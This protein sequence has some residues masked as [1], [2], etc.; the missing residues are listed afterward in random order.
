MFNH[1][2]YK[3]EDLAAYKDLAE[4]GIMLAHPVTIGDKT[5]RPDINLPYHSSIK[6]FH[7][8]KD[9]SAKAHDIASKLD[10]SPPNPKN[11]N[12]TPDTFKDRLGND[13]HVLKLRGSSPDKMKEHNS[14][15]SHM[16][17]PAKHDF[18]AHV[19]VDKD[20]WHKIKNSGAK[21]AHEAGLK[22]GPAQLYQGHKILH[23]YKKSENSMLKHFDNK[24][25]NP[26][27]AKEAIYTNSK[28]KKSHGKALLLKDEDFSRYIQD[29]PGLEE[30]IADH[31]LNRLEHH[32]GQDPDMIYHGWVGGVKHAYKMKR[33]NKDLKELKEK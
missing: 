20:T 1:S 2:L 6:V 27:V 12:I 14:K 19:S 11:V 4:K 15:F 26:S 7:P 28:L 8:E 32:F 9:S 29:N 22:F 31:H 33:N 16:G 21:T 24:K 17:Y 10:M 30:E 5:H 3:A 25:L 18:Q 23:T 13:I